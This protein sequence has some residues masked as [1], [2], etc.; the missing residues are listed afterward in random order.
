ML[1]C[2]SCGTVITKIL[3]CAHSGADYYCILKKLLSSFGWLA[4]GGFWLGFIKTSGVGGVGVICVCAGV[5]RM[6]KTLSGG[7]EEAN[8]V[9]NQMLVK[10]FFFKSENCT[11]RVRFKI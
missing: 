3:E 2:A 7:V 8:I 5:V 6:R 1:P 9:R 4:T 10:A 11:A